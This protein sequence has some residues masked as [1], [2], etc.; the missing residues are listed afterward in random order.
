MVDW[1]EWKQVW[2]KD[3][4]L[5]FQGRKLKGRK[6]PEKKKKRSFLPLRKKKK[7]KKCPM[8]VMWKNSYPTRDWK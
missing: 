4:P 3:A 7:K 5:D 2:L 6:F 8:K 1:N